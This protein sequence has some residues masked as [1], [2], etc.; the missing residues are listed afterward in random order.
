MRKRPQL[1]LAVPI[2]LLLGP[3]LNG[4]GHR[5]D[6]PLERAKPQS[7]AQQPAKKY[8]EAID[9]GQ[10]WEMRLKEL[11]PADAVEYVEVASDCAHW[12]GEEPYDKDREREI[13]RNS[14]QYCSKA[15][16]LKKQIEAKY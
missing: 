14:K 1:H 8:D 7:K 4:C 13:A 3:S 9:P 11:L 2:I 5:Q 6:S 16:R 10:L 15:E 12:S